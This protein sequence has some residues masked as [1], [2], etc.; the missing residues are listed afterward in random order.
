M[1]VKQIAYNH[2]PPQNIEAEQSVLGAM[3]Q[4]PEAV[5]TAIEKLRFE[6]FYK[7]EHQKIFKAISDLYATDQPIDI[8]TVAEALTQSGH[9]DD[10]GDRS[11]I[12][13]LTEAVPGLANH[14]HHCNIVLDK[15]LRNQLSETC[16]SIAA[17]I[18]DESQ[19]TNDLIDS[20][21]QQIFKIKEFN[22]K[23]PVRSMA[24]ILPDAYKNIECAK[25]GLT[26]L[27]SGYRDLDRLTSG[28]Q[29]SDLVIIACRPSVGKTSLALNITD[30]LAVK[31]DIPVLIFS[32]EMKD[33]S[34][35][36]RLLCSHARVSSYRMRNGYL[37]DHEWTNLSL[38]ARPISDAPIFID[39][40][41]NIDLLEM[42]AKA[43]R[44]VSK[45][46]IQMIIIDYIQLIRGP[47][48]ESRQQEVTEIS[49]S[50]KAMAR[51]LDVVVLALS[52]LSRQVELRGK[53]A[54][55]QLSDLR[56]SGALEQDADA[57]IFIHRHRDEMGDLG[58]DAEIILSK[59][60][61]GP[62]GR[63]E[64]KFLKDY[65]RFEQLDD[66]RIEDYTE[67]Y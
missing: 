40:T 30:Y 59:Q 34:L 54:K 39:D 33:E 6:Y 9:L 4:F 35:A 19:T 31:N 62:T 17:N 56:E 32:I 61:N 63:V 41:P 18:Y 23:R 53:A 44:H 28:F 8:V 49:R 22:L 11:Y 24:D 47:K 25:G 45:H 46:K 55:P 51:E 60:R 52:Q 16:Q 12:A 27:P 10:A 67:R 42:R 3:L 14:E 36:Q 64:M 21:E 1:S 37:K 15:A 5:D 7:P 29:R 50:I 57:V 26:G 66:K 48:A 43:R 58:E 38:A 20:A 2:I 13:G 65:T